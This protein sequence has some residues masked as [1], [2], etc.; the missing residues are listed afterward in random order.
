M[1][2]EEYVT[3]RLQPVKVLVSMLK[4]EL[5][6][7]KDEE[8]VMSREDLDDIVSTIEIYIEEYL[9]ASSQAKGSRR[10]TS[11]EMSAAY[12]ADKKHTMKNVA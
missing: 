5:K 6:L 11:Q 4:K 1:T 9:L 3:R 7:S 2:F 10:S 12:P 8:I